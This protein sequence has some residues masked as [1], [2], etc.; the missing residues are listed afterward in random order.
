MGPRGGFGRGMG[1]QGGGPPFGFPGGGPRPEG[2]LPAP[3]EEFFN[4]LDHN[5]DGNVDR[6]E[7]REM[8]HSPGPGGRRGEGGPPP[9]PRTG[10][11]RPA[12][13]V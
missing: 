9:G 11:R 8:F 5:H 13:E 1:R 2:G 3:V 12:V 7:L 4:Q 10:G 6:E